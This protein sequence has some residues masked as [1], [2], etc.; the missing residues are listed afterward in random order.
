MTPILVILCYYVTMTSG[1]THY[2]TLYLCM[3]V[4]QTL[5]RITTSTAIIPDT[6]VC[7]GR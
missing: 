7:G 2:G 4:L 1:S 5:V 6:N 3:E